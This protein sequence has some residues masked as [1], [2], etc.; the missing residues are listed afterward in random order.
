[1]FY[2]FGQQSYLRDLTEGSAGG[3]KRLTA[4]PECHRLLGLLELRQLVATGGISVL[5][6]G[7]VAPTA[8]S[9]DKVPV[10]ILLC[11]DSHPSTSIPLTYCTNTR[12]HTLHVCKLRNGSVKK[13]ILGKGFR[14]MSAL[15]LGEQTSGTLGTAIISQRIN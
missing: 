1:M 13:L 5:F 9:Q 10:A 3:D 7:P 12:Q 8:S 6:R 14:H 4:R 2:Q 15:S 11:E